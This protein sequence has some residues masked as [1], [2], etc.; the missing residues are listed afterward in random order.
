MAETLSR[1]DSGNASAQNLSSSPL[2]PKNVKI[3]IYITVI[4]PAVLFGCETCSLTISI[5]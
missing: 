4:L 5:D 1:F 3:K 2:L